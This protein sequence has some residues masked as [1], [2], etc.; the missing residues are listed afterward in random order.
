MATFEELYLQC[1]DKYIRIAARK[2]NERDAEDIVQDTFL[3]IFQKKIPVLT[4]NYCYGVLHHKILLAR[5]QHARNDKHIKE[6]LSGDIKRPL[7][8]I[9]KQC[10]ER[11][12]CK[13]GHVF[14]GFRYRD[15]TKHRSC[16]V[17]LKDQMERRKLKNRV[18]KDAMRKM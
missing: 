9:V 1:R 15:G 13:N 3:T 10:A 18:K 7:Q 6:Y 17:C 11:T 16:S 12:H 4:E 5:L 8:G 2:Y 14:D